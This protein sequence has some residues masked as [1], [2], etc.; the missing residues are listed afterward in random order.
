MCIYRC[1]KKINFLMKIRKQSIERKGLSFSTDSLGQA[2]IKVGLRIYYLL[3]E[4]ISNLQ[5]KH[6]KVKVQFQQILDKPNKL[7]I[8]EQRN[9]SME[10]KLDKFNCSKY[11]I[12]WISWLL[13]NNEMKEWRGSRINSVTAN[14]T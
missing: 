11:W 14:T 7:H 1:S 5:H 3:S 4:F 6:W 2:K 8:L 12:N 10:R 13:L 9:E